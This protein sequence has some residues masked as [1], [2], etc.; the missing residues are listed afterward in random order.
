MQSVTY[1]VR[2]LQKRVSSEITGRTKQGCSRFLGGQRRLVTN[3]I[4]RTNQATLYFL[5]DGAC[6]RAGSGEHLLCKLEKETPK[7][8]QLP[9]ICFCLQ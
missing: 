8:L 1:V 4:S 5:A 7:L 6:D 3:I 9:F 2:L